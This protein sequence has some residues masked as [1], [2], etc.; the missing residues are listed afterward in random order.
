MRKKRNNTALIMTRRSKWNKEKEKKEGK[1]RNFMKTKIKERERKRGNN[2]IAV[3]KERKKEV[4][5]ERRKIKVIK[6]RKK[7]RKK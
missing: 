2:K 7:E 5:K 3:T 4:T 6:E 1:Y